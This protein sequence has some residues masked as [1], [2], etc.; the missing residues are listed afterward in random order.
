[1]SKEKKG[2]GEWINP[3]Y[4]PLVT[5]IPIDGWLILKTEPYAGVELSMYI[6]AILFLIFSGAVETNQE[7]VKHR[8]FGYIYLVSA[9]L[10]G[11]VGLILWLGNS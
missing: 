5:A 10:F 9:L 4:L 7:E 11:A 8:V 3:L 2:V 6:I 1:M